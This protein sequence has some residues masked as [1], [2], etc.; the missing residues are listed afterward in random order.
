VAQVFSP[1]LAA[2]KEPRLQLARELHLG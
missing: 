2:R 1:G